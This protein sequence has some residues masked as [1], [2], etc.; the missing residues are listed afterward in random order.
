[1]EWNFREALIEKLNQLLD[2]QRTYWKQRS[3]VRWVKDGGAGTKLFHAATTIKHRN[4]LIAQ[5]QK[6]NGEV[7]HN[8]TE[9]ELIL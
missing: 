3:K 2:Q 1:M 9:K 4:N 7:V 5:L 8:H 6:P